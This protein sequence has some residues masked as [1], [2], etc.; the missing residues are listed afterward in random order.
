MEKEKTAEDYKNIIL[1]LVASATLADHMGDMWD[2]LN[3]ALKLIGEDELLEADYESE[4]PN[5]LHKRGIKT[6][7]GT[8]VGTEDEED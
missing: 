5:L 3:Q 2:D 1:S 4:L 6:I 7:W 8:E